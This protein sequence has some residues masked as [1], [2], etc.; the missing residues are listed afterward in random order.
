[1]AKN[2]DST[3]CA[4]GFWA[5]AGILAGLNLLCLAI[6][7][8]SPSS[9]V[10]SLTSDVAGIAIPLLAFC[11]SFG[12][13]TRRISWRLLPM[14]WLPA[15]LGA[16]SLIYALGNCL[17]VYE[18]RFRHGID[19][20][21][22]ADLCY[23]GQYVL[24][25]A[26]ALLWPLRPTH[27]AM[28]WRTWSDGL[29]VAAGVL[30]FGWVYLIGP[31][32]KHTGRGLF[33]I[34]ANAAF[35]VLDSLILVSLYQMVRR[36]L[37]QRFRAATG[38]LMAGLVCTVL[39][40]LYYTQASISQT[41]RS[42]SLLDLSWMLT[43]SLVGLS[44]LLVRGKLSEPGFQKIQAE[45][46]YVVVPRKWALG[47]PFIL[48]PATGI[49]ALFVS[50]GD[51]EPIIRRGLYVCCFFLVV[52]ILIRQMLAVNENGSLYNKL[53][54]AYAQLE[55]RNQQIS[56]T[57]VEAERM[58]LE[59]RDMASILESQ[60]K[61]LLE[62]NS[63]LEQ[64]AT[65]DGMTGLANHRAFQE[66]L[67]V[68]VGQSRRHQ[69]PLCL[70]LL[71]VDFFKQYNDNYGHPAGD[72]VLRSIAKL[73]EESTRA[74]DLAARYGGEEF[75]LLMPYADSGEALAILERI[76]EI[77]ATFTFKHRRVTVSIGLSQISADC[78]TPEMMIDH[79]DRALYTAKSR[80]RNQVVSAADLQLS[81]PVVLSGGSAKMDGS[82]PMGF[83]TI[84]AAG[85]NLKPEAL[86]HEPQCA[87]A[88]GLLATLELKDPMTRGCALRIMWYAMRFAQ[89]CRNTGALDITPNMMRALGF[90]AL[91]H[92]V[93]RLGVREEVLTYPEKFT[94][95]MRIEI[96]KHPMIGAELV[97][98]FPGLT[99]ALPVILHHH[100]RWDGGGYPFGLQGS[101]IPK[102]ARIVSYVDAFNAMASDRP[103][104]PAMSYEEICEEMKRNAGKQFDPNL[105][106]IFLAIPKSDWEELRHRDPFGLGHQNRAA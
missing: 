44:G 93:G 91:L 81:T 79:A 34:V 9:E 72:E 15:V 45:G 2:C 100:E 83:A 5:W 37:D 18:T 20:P 77:V 106:D 70:A 47:A 98:K 32:L 84:L 64:L 71:D 46:E 33:G 102:A 39:G 19:S 95:E 55:V 11:A 40:D 92:D 31:A 8:L 42:G 54:E 28:R 63:V 56:V 41:Y 88:A 25:V 73:L 52:A 26:A 86:S 14:K 58:N 97:K 76:R 1:M 99:E 16:A 69:H 6:L 30:A 35:P 96:E 85:L 103:Y 4:K 17:Y 82:T 49:L 43:C 3:R 23:L 59:L 90:G 74:S 62:T 36:G 101:N 65:R 27:R 66:R 7:S 60:N 53:R 24:F 75:A 87:L 89:E 67:R 22:T 78:A 51:F 21:W 38:L 105:L 13:G 10:K 29:V 12:V 94:S 50:M 57:A 80:G 68:E 104:A 61:T 48:A